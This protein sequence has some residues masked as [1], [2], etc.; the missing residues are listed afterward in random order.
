M[1]NKKNKPNNTCEPY[2]K[3]EFLEHKGLFPTQRHSCLMD[4]SLVTRTE[5]ESDPYKILQK[6]KI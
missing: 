2:I 3:L 5:E 1:K 4:L 6:G